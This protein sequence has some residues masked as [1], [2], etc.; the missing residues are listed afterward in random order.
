MKDEIT[1]SEE[2]VIT[3]FFII[4]VIAT[5]VSMASAYYTALFD[6]IESWARVGCLIHGNAALAVLFIAI[7]IL[8]KKPKKQ[9][10]N[11]L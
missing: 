11:K 2:V 10:H 1:E 6:D 8:F 9:T 3:V 7:K 4:G 5:I